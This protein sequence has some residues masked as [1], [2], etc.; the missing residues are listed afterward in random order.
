MIRAKKLILH[1]GS[2]KTG[3]TSIQSYLSSKYRQL[4][5]DGVL[6]PKTSRMRDDGGLDTAHHRL[7]DALDAADGAMTLSLATLLEQIAKEM[8]QAQCETLLMSSETFMNFRRPETLRRYF[9]S[10][11]VQIVATFRNQAEFISSMYYTE[12][13]HRKVI[14][15]PMAYLDGFNGNLLDYASSLAPWRRAWPEALFSVSLFERGTLARDFPAANLIA[16]IGLDWPQVARDNQIEHR[17]LPAQATLFLRTLAA[18][19][20]DANAFFEIFEVCHRNPSWFAP[21]YENFAPA[22]LQQIFDD[23]AIQNQALAAHFISCGPL[24]F[25]PPIL[26]DQDTWEQAMGNPDAVFATILKRIVRKAATA[27]A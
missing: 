21:V 3:T 6:Y 27:S 11:E 9:Q 16:Q 18:S 24:E 22:I 26:T 14:D 17:S 10:D 25:A 8:Q 5:A 15:L 20:W 12:V 19:G 2:W 4:K 13:C 1:I 23:H 7:R